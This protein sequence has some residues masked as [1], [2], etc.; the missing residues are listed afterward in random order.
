ML[1]SADETS[2]KLGRV[3]T[4]FARFPANR[5]AAG[6]RPVSASVAIDAPRERVFD[7]V[8]DL[9]ARPAFTDHFL[10]EYRLERIDP[11]GVGAAARFR[12]LDSGE[13]LDTVIESV[14]RPH[15]IRERGYGGRWN[16]IP[17]ITV[18]ELAEG[19]APGACEVTVT[20]WTEPTHPLDRL[21]ELTGS[22]SWFRRHWARAVIRLKEVAESEQPI[23]RVSVAGG[24]RLPGAPA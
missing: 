21:R 4:E 5:I 9:S 7:V 12:L 8:C 23:E 18:W 22:A 6:M 13:W 1:T 11:V 24:D 16:R 19:P 2:T 10:V 17:A 20:F 15:L 14:E 3:C